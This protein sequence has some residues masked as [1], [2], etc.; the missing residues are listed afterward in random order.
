MVKSLELLSCVLGWKWTLNTLIINNIWEIL[1]TWA[2]E[3]TNSGVN[4]SSTAVTDT[5]VASEPDIN[6][7]QKTSEVKL[8]S[9][10]SHD[11]FNMN[12]S[13]VCSCQIGAWTKLSN[14][15]NCLEKTKGFSAARLQDE[16]MPGYSSCTDRIGDGGR[17]ME[18]SGEMFQFCLVCGNLR[19]SILPQPRVIL[20]IQ[21]L[22]KFDDIYSV[23]L[24]VHR[25]SINIF[26]CR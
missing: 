14:F 4:L 15:E 7:S 23:R 25:L 13:S 9:E 26:L 21:L 17:V 12:K 1:K 10:G 22:G 5:V 24:C 3:E 18:Q 8:K 16:S 2:S 19:G 11:N 20:C 6:S